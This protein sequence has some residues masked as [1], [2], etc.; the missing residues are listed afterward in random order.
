[1]PVRCRIHDAHVGEG[2]PVLGRITAWPF[3][4]PYIC[5][6][7][8]EDA[9]DVHTLWSLLC[10]NVDDQVERNIGFFCEEYAC[11]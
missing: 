9:Y 2:F 6:A 1:M 10:Y 8:V 4:V 3:A 11:R 7:T 5:A